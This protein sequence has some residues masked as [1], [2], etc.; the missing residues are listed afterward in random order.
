MSGSEEPKDDSRL[1]H[2]MSTNTR[3]H[4]F[5][6]QIVPDPPGIRLILSCLRCLA[7]SD[8]LKMLWLRLF[9]PGVRDSSNLVATIIS[10]W[11]SLLFQ[12]S[13][14]PVIL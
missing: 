13:Y 5:N 10:S 11:R 9:S 3:Q 12:Q 7:D 1:R 14:W 2:R 8:L 4:R 6:Q